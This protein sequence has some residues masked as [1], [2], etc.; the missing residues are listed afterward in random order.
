MLNKSAFHADLAKEASL[1]PYLDA[2]YISGL[3]KYSVERIFELKKQR[4]GIDLV[5]THKISKKQFTI[6]EK[7][8][9]DYINESL[10][11][12]AFE[13]TYQK[14]NLRKTGWF[15]DT[16]KQTDFYALITSIYKDEEEFTSAN[17]LFVNRKLL[18]N[19][20][21]E[22]GITLETLLTKL[23]KTVAHGRILIPELNEKSEGF[24]FVS[25]KNKAEK[26]IN[27]VLKLEW[28]V[29]LGVAKK[30]KNSRR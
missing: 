6:D 15:Y 2:R 14:N 26:P 29:A 1:Q 28:L 9:L 5:F 22:R 3:K 16:A 17:I 27:L 11:T 18:Q 30:L 21:L 13:L 10:P 12:F 4:L 19:K 24:L 7:A 25:S 23:P 8:Q 20:L